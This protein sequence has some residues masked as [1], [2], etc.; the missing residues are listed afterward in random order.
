VFYANH[1][2]G[3]DDDIDDDDGCLKEQIVNENVTEDASL[4]STRLVETYMHC[5]FC[6]Q[7]VLW[8]C[9]NV[10]LFPLNVFSNIFFNFYFD[11]YYK[12][13]YGSTH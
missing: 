11:I 2:G 5:C 10:S 6:W 4:P 3:G 7:R 8:S 1:N 9:A 12:D 13:N